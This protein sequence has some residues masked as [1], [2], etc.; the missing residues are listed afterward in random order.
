MW[1]NLI[2]ASLTWS[3]LGR[4]PARLAATLFNRPIRPLHA[5]LV[6]RVQLMTRE[7]CR[8]Q[9]PAW[10][11]TQRG[12]RARLR[13]AAACYGWGAPETGGPLSLPQAAG[14]VDLGGAAN[15][16]VLAAA[17]RDAAGFTFPK[18]LVPDVAFGRCM[19]VARREWPRLGLFFV[20]SVLALWGPSGACRGFSLCVRI[21]RRGGGVIVGYPPGARCLVPGPRGLPSARCL[22]PD[23]S[24]FYP[25]SI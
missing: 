11:G 15:H 5:E 18:N 8:R 6:L 13:S 12:I 19:Q 3:A 25:L 22:V 1:T 21:L 17:L 20:L 2:L 24:N 10:R 23:N 16:P 14:S 9:A 7:S 4:P